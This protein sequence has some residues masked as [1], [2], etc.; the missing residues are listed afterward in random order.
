MKNYRNKSVKL[1]N[2]KTGKEVNVGD[3]ITNFRGDIK[4][5]IS[6][7][8]PHKASASGYVNDHYAGVYDCEFV[9]INL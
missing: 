4:T 2:T 6:M 1:V 5:L 9:E 8:A 3:Q 7:R